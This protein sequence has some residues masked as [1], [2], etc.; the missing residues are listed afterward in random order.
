MIIRASHYTFSIDTLLTNF[1]YS[2]DFC[3]KDIV[4]ISLHS[5]L[6]FF[7]HNSSENRSNF[8]NYDYYDNR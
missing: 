4:I 6:I 5:L 2:F 3:F 7:G 1:V 8:K